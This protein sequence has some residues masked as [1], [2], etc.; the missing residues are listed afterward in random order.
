MT[1]GSVPEHED[2]DSAIRHVDAN[3][4]VRVVAVRTPSQVDAHGS[5]GENAETGRRPIPACCGSVT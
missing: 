5:S 3:Y 1:G 2:D 4:C